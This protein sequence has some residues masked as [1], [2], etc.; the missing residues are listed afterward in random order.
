MKSNL[1]ISIKPLKVFLPL[2]LDEFILRISLFFYYR[3]SYVSR[4]DLSAF[5]ATAINR[6]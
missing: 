4:G 2:D 3:K 1:A 6:E 5:F